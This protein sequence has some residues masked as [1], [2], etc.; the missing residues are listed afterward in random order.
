MVNVGTEK[1]KLQIWDTAGQ[2]RFRTI[3]TSFYRGSRGIFIIYD[4]TDR[5]TFT[6]MTK[7]LAEL[8][9]HAPINITKILIGNKVDSPNRVVTTQEGKTLADKHNLPFFETSAKTGINI[10]ESFEKLTS[11]TLHKQKELMCPEKNS[12]IVVSPN[13]LPQSRCC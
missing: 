7:W 10:N 5:E 9:D 3:T 8:D 13:R 2:E 11:I 6:N 12:M 1:I 4:V